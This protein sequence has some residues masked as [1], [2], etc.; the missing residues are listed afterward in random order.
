MIKIL[1]VEQIREAD[2][3]TIENEPIASIDLMERAATAIFQ[4]MLP[5]LKEGQH[6]NIFSGMGNNGG[7]GLVLARLFHL[8]AYHVKTYVLKTTAKGSTDFEVNLERLKNKTN[9]I[10]EIKSLNDFPD[11]QADTIIIDALFGSGLNREC[12]DLAADLIQHINYSQAV[13]ISIDIPSG[14]FADHPLP[15]KNTAVIQADYTY[16]FQWP[17]L[18]LLLPENEFYVGQWEIVPIG[19]HPEYEQSAKVHHYLTELADIRGLLKG[20]NRFS[21]K[22]NYGHAL[23]IAGSHDKPGAAILAA[24]ACLRSGAGLLHVHLPKKAVLPM[25]CNFPEAMISIDEDEDYF[26]TIPKLQAYNGIAVGPGLGTEQS[27]ANALKLLIQEAVVPLIL[28]ADALN[29][30]SENKTWLAFLP[31]NSILSPHPGEFARIVGSWSNSFEKLQLQASLSLKHQIYII[32]KGAFTS[33]SAPDGTIWFNPTGNPGMASAGSGDVLSGILLGLVSRGYQP[34]EAC[35]IAVYIHG[36]AG[37]KAAKEIGLES[38]IASDIIAKLPN[39]FSNCY[40]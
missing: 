6:I 8:Q 38:M 3:Y 18:A 28:D 40:G 33:I 12:T 21:H 34:L 11:I 23:L 2:A 39:A 7:D 24:Q 17:K 16:T 36:L 37:D 4:R 15:S 25:Q 26:S 35:L 5:K 14:L 20:R 1:T 29:I 13:T 32:L 9:E 31:K 19:L 27:T 10:Y 30:L 22:G